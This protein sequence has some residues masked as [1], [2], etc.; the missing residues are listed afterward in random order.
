MSV[1]LGMNIDW[2]YE[3][4]SA[5]PP[6]SFFGTVGD[7]NIT[8]KNFPDILKNNKHL[9]VL[10]SSSACRECCFHE[11]NFRKM[12]EN[13]FEN[14]FENYNLTVKIGRV[15][16]VN[17]PWF[18]HQFSLT[19]I[20]ETIYFY[21][22]NARIMFNTKDGKSVMYQIYKHASQFIPLDS[23]EKFIEFIKN[24]RSS[25]FRRQ[26][27]IFG[28]NLDSD[29]LDYFHKITVHATLRLDIKFGL[30]SNLT[31]SAILKRQ[32]QGQRTLSHDQS[33]SSSELFSLSSFGIRQ[34]ANNTIY[35]VHY[36]DEF[37]FGCKVYYFDDSS[38]IDFPT[39]FTKFSIEPVEHISPLN[40]EFL[41]SRTKIFVAVFIKKSDFDANNDLMIALR[42][43]AHVY[44]GLTIVWSYFEDSKR[45]ARSVGLFF[46]QTPCIS[47]VFPEKEIKNVTETD[48]SLV[49][50]YS[51]VAIVDHHYEKNFEGLQTFFQRLAEKDIMMGL[52]EFLLPARQNYQTFRKTFQMFQ[53][54][55]DYLRNSVLTNQ[56][57][58]VIYFV[59]SHQKFDVKLLRK[60]MSV[61]WS[62]FKR[63]RKIN[64][65]VM[66]YDLDS[67]PSF[68]N[69]LLECFDVFL[70]TSEIKQTSKP[71]RILKQGEKT[72]EVAVALLKLK[73]FRL[74]KHL[75]F[76]PSEINDGLNFD[77]VFE[78]KTA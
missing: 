47:V 21:E 71:Y 2:D 16:L 3:Q 38:E 67:E 25:L 9:V 30:V 33:K 72:A 13:I 52:P 36:P 4:V 26:K 75:E 10:I 64:F 32:Y 60:S 22:G 56:K 1:S 70:T 55:N 11:R 46:C 63:I 77:A 42:K 37:E 15:D 24:D 59:R 78:G 40:S 57:D 27:V 28:V 23:E 34:L 19:Q 41:Y 20:P 68:E 48:P 8:K 54:E 49:F 29:L 43:L 58:Y 18:F 76:L 31:L 74:E 44:P 73:K 66:V 50:D 61:L 6:E 5:C 65:A 62:F 69:L 7:F 35:I 17:E 51:N 45:Y 12:K 39:F 14:S 53:V